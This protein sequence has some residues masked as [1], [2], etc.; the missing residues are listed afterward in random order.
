MKTKQIC[1]VF[2]PVGR[3][4]HPLRL[5]LWPIS[6]ITSY[7]L[8]ISCSTLVTRSIKTTCRLTSPYMHRQPDVHHTSI[9]QLAKSCKQATCSDKRMYR[10]TGK[11]GTH[12]LL[13][14]NGANMGGIMSAAGTENVTTPN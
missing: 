5:R 6:H 1:L 13:E 4:L 11:P 2:S 12:T 7:Y 9:I 8:V 10:M 3:H 14:I